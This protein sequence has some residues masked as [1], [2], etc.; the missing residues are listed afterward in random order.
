MRPQALQLRE[1]RILAVGLLVAVL[2]LLLVVVIVPVFQR[3]VTAYQAVGDNSFRVER[4]Q[5]TVAQLPD[6]RALVAALE[7]A[8]AEQDL[9]SRAPSES[10]AAARL[11]QRFNDIVSRHQGELQSTRVQPAVADG[12]IHRIGMRVQMRGDSATLG[13]ILADLEADRPLVF[14]DRLSVQAQREFDRQRRTAYRGLTEISLDVHIYW[15]PEEPRD[16]AGVAS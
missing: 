10:L 15:R 13:A 2:I 6:L 3:A 4:L 16:P 12:D 9:V 8:G 14:I 7:A 1:R 11:Q 5:A